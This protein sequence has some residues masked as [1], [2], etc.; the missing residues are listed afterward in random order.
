MHRGVTLTL[1]LQGAAV[2][3]VATLSAFRA[4]K[5]DWGQIAEHVWDVPAADRAECGHLFIV[6]GYGKEPLVG[7]GIPGDSLCAHVDPGDA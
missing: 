4:I 1:W 3:T 6:F 2:A 7:Y 5:Q